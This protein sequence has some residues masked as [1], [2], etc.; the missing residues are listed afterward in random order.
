MVRTRPRTLR[1]LHVAAELYPWVKTGGLGDVVAA[2]PPA[3]IGEG[4]DARLCLPGFPAFLDAFHLTDAVRLETPFAGERVRVALA[5]LPGSKVA[6]YL[7]DHPAFYDRPGGPYGGSDG[8]EWPDNHRRF[9][10]SS[11]VAAALGQGA[12]PNWRPDI[13]H[14]H[15]WHAGLAP[16][17]LRA[18][19]ASAKTVFTVHNLAYQGFFAAGI[20]PELSLPASFFTIDGI[21][22]FG[23][24]SFLK[25][26][27]FYA[28]RLTTV[29]PT[30]AREI[31]TPEFGEALDGLLRGRADML[32]GILNGVDPR[33]WDPARD[34]AIPQPYNVETAEAGKAAAKAELR[35]RLHLFDGPA[36]V[37]GAVSRLVPQKG[38]DLLLAALPDLAA[39][40]GQLA[41][42]GSGDHDLEAGFGEAAT[43]RRGT[44]GVEIGYDEALARLIIAGSDCIVIPSRFEPCGLTQLYALRYGT[45]PLVRRTGGLTD[46][47]VDATP[48]RLKD[49]T[50]TGFMFEPATAEALAATIEWASA[51][52]A[53]RDSWRQ[54]MRQAM[55]RDFS[56][57]QS[58]RQYAALYRQLVAD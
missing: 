8:R 37:F 25:A 51:Q 38:L 41:L 30:Y 49:K 13:V 52:Y 46:T 5:T 26:G 32:T 54:M 1:V 14:G 3:L 39:G 47:V 27:L 18:A 48:A 15:D 55:T 28:D 11:W 33:Y 19:G 2:L 40:G 44:I 16:A 7:V 6:A 29:S 22:F 20:F 45:L 21:E 58:A 34:D 10:L 50:A 36:P 35:R 4:V 23:G 53:N 17:Y 31:Q 57:A 43:A 42:L 56:W 12:D 24:L 9:A